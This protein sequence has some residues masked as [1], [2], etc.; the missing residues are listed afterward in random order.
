MRIVADTNMAVSGLLWQGAPRR[1]V[2]LGRSQQITLMT[3]PALL[4]ELADVIGRDKFTARIH[5]AGLSA[6]SL[7]EDYSGIAQRVETAP[8]TQPVCRDPDDDEVLACALA[9]QADFIVSGDNDLL[10]LGSYQGIAILTTAQALDRIKA[11]K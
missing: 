6:K 8:L 1:L 7:V 5:K 9:A 3:S 4:A 11:A 10:T 2:E